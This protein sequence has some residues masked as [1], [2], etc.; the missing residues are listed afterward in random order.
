M[1]KLLIPVLTL[2]S[3]GFFGFG[4]TNEVNAANPD[5]QVRVQ[6]GQGRHRGWYNRNY[7]R[8]FRT[9]RT[10]RIV[11]RGFRTYRETYLV[12]AFGNGQMQTTLIS[13]QRIG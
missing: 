12:R 6:I 10:T 4:S 5:P 7:N 13:R 9:Y 1:K 2:A 3:F 11:R 8:R